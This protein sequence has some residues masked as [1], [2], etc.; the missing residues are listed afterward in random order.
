MLAVLSTERNSRHQAELAQA[1]KDLLNR[2]AHQQ[3]RF[4]S[5]PVFQ[6]P[7]LFILPTVGKHPLSFLILTPFLLPALG[8]TVSLLLTFS[9][10]QLWVIFFLLLFYFTLFILSPWFCFSP[11]YIHASLDLF[12]CLVRV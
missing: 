6:L 7:Q 8:I 2:P 9:K 11:C 4:K 3:Q 5:L 10:S 1:S 12:F